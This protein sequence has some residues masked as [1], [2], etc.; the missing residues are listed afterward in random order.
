MAKAV[1]VNKDYVAKFVEENGFPEVGHFGEDGKKD[2]QKFYKHLSVE[3]LQEWID[4][5]GLEYTAVESEQI[6]RMRMCMAILYKH[7]PKAPAKKKESKYA[8]YSTDDLMQ[9]A[10]DKEVAFEVTE[11]DRIMRMRAIMALRAAG[12]IE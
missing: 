7:Y 12:H 3:Q 4:L 5:E 6:T 2:L 10:M 9:M 11:D 1:K 8:K